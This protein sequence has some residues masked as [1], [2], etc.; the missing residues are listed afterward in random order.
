MNLKKQNWLRYEGWEKKNASL[1]MMVIHYFFNGAVAGQADA[2][3]AKQLRPPERASCCWCSTAP[4]PS[5]PFPPWPQASHPTWRT[6]M[7]VPVKILA[8]TG[9][10]KS[11]F[12]IEMAASWCCA[13]PLANDR[14]RPPQ[15]LANDRPL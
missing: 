6:L 7:E 11:K 13:V 15:P 3:V 5:C 9:L 12:H 1:R 4:S 14:Q 8:I 10:E 2:L